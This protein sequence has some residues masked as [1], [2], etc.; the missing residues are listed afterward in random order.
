MSAEENKAIVRR[1]AE[2]IFSQGNLD[3]ADEIY[4]PDYVQRCS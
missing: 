2:E 1:E 3:A 4:A